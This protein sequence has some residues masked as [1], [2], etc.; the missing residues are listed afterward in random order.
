[1]DGVGRASRWTPCM[2]MLPKVI[3]EADK[4]QPGGPYAGTDLEADEFCREGV[5]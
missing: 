4:W 3:K 2:D 1:M 5:D